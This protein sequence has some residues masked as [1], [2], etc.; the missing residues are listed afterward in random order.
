[1]IFESV[2]A[3]DRPLVEEELAV[4]AFEAADAV[5]EEDIVVL[6]PVAEVN[7]V[8]LE[9][10]AVAGVIGSN[11]MPFTPSSTSWSL[12]SFGIWSTYTFPVVLVSACRRCV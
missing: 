5:E 4:P 3:T 12:P 11:C 8:G 7:V 6:V 10:G 1:L 2:V 9:A